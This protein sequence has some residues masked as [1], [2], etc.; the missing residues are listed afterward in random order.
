MSE[1][2]TPGEER[3]A[4]AGE[5][6]GDGH[7]TSVEVAQ[8]TTPEQFLVWAVRYW[9]YSYRQDVDPLVVMAEGFARAR[10]E[11][12][13]ADFD[14]IMTIT[15]TVALRSLDVRCPRCRWLGDGERDILAAAALAQWHHPQLA[16]ARL[17]DWLAP[18]SARLTMPYLRDVTTTMRQRHLILPLHAD[19]L[20]PDPASDVAPAELARPSISVLVQ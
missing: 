10:L 16:R 14:S 19:Y 13:L 15:A 11:S 3:A 12:R 2:Y 7:V 6:P 20:P 8:L 5:R 1:T 4:Q 18:A 9:V 17:E